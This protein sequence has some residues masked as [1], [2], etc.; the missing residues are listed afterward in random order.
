MRGNNAEDLQENRGRIRTEKIRESFV[1][2]EARSKGSDIPQHQQCRKKR[3]GKHAEDP[4]N[5]CD[6]VVPGRVVRCR[7]RFADCGRR[8]LCIV[9][10]PVRIS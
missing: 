9:A 1:A 4:D 3:D 7:R 10:F 6:P 5:Q 8:E 2:G